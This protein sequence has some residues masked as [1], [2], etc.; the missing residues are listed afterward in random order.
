MDVK[1]P[2]LNGDILNANDDL[3]KV[4]TKDG[5][6]KWAMSEIEKL[7]I[8][9]YDVFDV[10]VGGL[11]VFTGRVSEDYFD[12]LLMLYKHIN[13]VP[14]DNKEMIFEVQKKKYK[15]LSALVFCIMVLLASVITA[16]FFKSNWIVLGVSL[17][18]FVGSFVYYQTQLP[19]SPF[20]GKRFL[21]FDEFILTGNIGVLYFLIVGGF[22]LIT[23]IVGRFIP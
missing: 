21:F 16:S 17:I 4:K 10:Y 14:F 5:I 6:K 1:F 19:K 12:R 3:I 23:G 8:Y 9:D 20:T 2:M 13:K 18:G 7:D 11:V 22:L 15:K